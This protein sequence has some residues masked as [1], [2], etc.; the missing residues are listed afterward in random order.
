MDEGATF[1]CSRCE[2]F[3]VCFVCE[4]THVKVS[5]PNT[6]AAADD[7]E[8]REKAKKNSQPGAED[9][10]ITID[11]DE[12]G[13]LIKSAPAPLLFRCDRC[14]QAAHYEHREW[15]YDALCSI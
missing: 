7:G 13:G 10:P 12:E 1:T 15:R 8:A 2:A 9:E 6:P 11:D 14:K 5:R 3:P 4:Q